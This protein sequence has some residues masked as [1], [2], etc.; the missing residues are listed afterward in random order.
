MACGAIDFDFDELGGTLRI[1]DD[2]LREF[3]EYRTQGLVEFGIVGRRNTARAGC[4]QQAGVV[5]R[6]IAIDRDRVETGI[7]HFP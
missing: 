6:R 7:D 3:T 1:A 4:N 5:G 2:R